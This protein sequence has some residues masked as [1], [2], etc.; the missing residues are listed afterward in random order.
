MH[1]DNSDDEM[2]AQHQGNDETGD[3][4]EEVRMVPAVTPARRLARRGPRIPDSDT[5]DEDL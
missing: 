4:D 5:S 1:L 2:I 3:S